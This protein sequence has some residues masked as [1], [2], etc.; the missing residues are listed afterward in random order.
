[1]Y[2]FIWEKMFFKYFR[3]NTFGS[4][5]NT[6]KSTGV[7]DSIFEYLQYITKQMFTDTYVFIINVIEIKK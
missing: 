6:S 4:V 1:M 5:Q 3:T 7:G 2:S